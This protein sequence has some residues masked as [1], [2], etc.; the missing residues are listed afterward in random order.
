MTHLPT[1]APLTPARQRSLAELR[2]AVHGDLRTDDLT[3]GMYAT[4]AS[5]YQLVPEAVLLPRAEGDLAAAARWAWRSGTPIT[6]RGGATSLAGQAVGTGLQ[7]D[8]SQHLDRLIELNLAARTAWVEPGMV[9]DRLNALLAPHG[10][11]FAPDISPGNRATIGGMV[12]NNSSGMYSL[13]YGKTIDHVLGLRCVLADGTPIDIGPLDDDGLRAKLAADSLE[14]RIYRTAMRLAN[15][16]AQAIA[17]RYPKL[18]RRV[19]GYNLDA[20]V[21][22][23]QPF[24]LAPLIVGSEGTLALIAAVKI[25]LTPRPPQRIIAILAFESLDAALDALMPC[26]ACEPAAVELMDELLLDLTRRSHEYAAP[27]AS[28][29]SG[30]PGALLQVEFFAETQRVL[31]QRCAALEASVRQSGVP[32][33]LTIAASQSQQAAVLSVRKAGLPLLQSISPDLRPETFVEDSAVEPAR[34]AAYVRRF[35]AICAAE[36]LRVAFYGHASVGL[37]HARPLLNLKRAEDVAAMRR[38]A[39]QICDLVLEFGGALSGEHGDGML[40][41]EFNRRVF[42]EQIYGA[43]VELK[44]SCDPKNILN[45]GKIVLAPPMDT[46]LRYGQRYATIP[47]QTHFSF[48]DSGGMAGAVELCNG[49]GLCRK[50]GS[51]TMCPSYMVTRDEEHSTRGRANAL[52]LALSG[53]LPPD[54]LTG[55]RMAQAMSLCVGCKGCTAECP[56]RVNLT[57]LK[58]EW[59]AMRH[60]AH[61]TPLR[62]LLFGNI[63]A[64]SALAS[65]VAPL[66]NVGLAIANAL[67]FP[68]RLLGISHRRALPR[69]ATQTLSQWMRR[70]TSAPVGG[71]RVLLF[72]DTFAEFND[73]HIGRAAVA[74]LEAMGYAVELPRRRICCGRPQISRGLLAD[75]RRLGRQQLDELAPYAAAGISIVGLEP[76]CLLTFRDEYLDLLGDRRAPAVASASLLFDEFVARE[77]ASG[78][79]ALAL[80]PAIAPFLIHGHCHQKALAGMSATAALLGRIPEATVREVDSG[81]CGMAGSFGYE[82]EHHAISLKMAERSLL[83]AVRASPEAIIVASGTSCR[84]QIAD[85][86]GRRAHHIAEILAMHL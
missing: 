26:L 40:R 54:A 70:R 36:G 80:R 13:V 78:A 68:Q 64:I 24:N 38:V 86:S 2:A 1:I 21:G 27:L 66:A 75:A 6:A 47:L 72:A 30:R 59:L 46:N 65:R 10:L 74:V 71:R 39:E 69:F 42:G 20:L 22:P 50:T 61:G 51:G 57:R 32:F 29:V 9:L 82:T 17:E 83:P 84:Q 41:G 52:R 77:L 67:A 31:Q 4:D 45:P 53:A 19:G 23:P 62:D 5:I 3:R 48:A 58:S 35:R 55:E 12:A 85:G 43:F 15:E 18:L 81:C 37:L 16:H 25:R 73:P 49:N 63:H 11:M 7:I 79:A 76:S 34:L 8:C 33:T 14:G 60:A 56:S 28:F 44:R